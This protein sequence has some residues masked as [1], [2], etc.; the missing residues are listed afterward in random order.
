MGKGTIE[1]GASMTFVIIVSIIILG[2]G[3]VFV[4]SLFK[5]ADEKAP[6]S[7]P[8]II[9]HANPDNL[10]YPEGKD[11]I[12]KPGE[13]EQ[14][15]VS[16]YN[17]GWADDEKVYLAFDECRDEDGNFVTGFDLNS[18]GQAIPWK[19]DRGY[20]AI[21][22]VEEG[23]ASGIY[24]CSMLAGALYDGFIDTDKPYHSRQISITVE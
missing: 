2:I 10:L 1:L 8:E 12:I 18:I 23:A 22:K 24:I 7:A 11:I 19:E 15:L 17:A 14:L 6:K 16:V 3:L 4:L 5:F 20:S 9:F 13:S 21:I